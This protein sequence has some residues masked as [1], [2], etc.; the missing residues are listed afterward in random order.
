M[1]R[2]PS[3][4]FRHPVHFLAV[5]LGSGA[6]PVAPG[7]WGTLA[8]VP[9]YLPLS[10]LA[11]WGYLLFLLVTAVAG[12][13]ICGKTSRDWRVHDHAGIVWDE[14]VGFW[15]TMFLVPLSW[16]SLVLGF[17]LFRWFDI[18]KPW[19]IRYLDRNLQ[20]G[21]GIMVDDI[22]AGILACL[23]LHGLLQLPVLL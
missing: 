17:L 21:A 12:L 3:S 4:S 11:P 22:L 6:A 16:S 5:G 8:A 18:W 19:P 23:V 7:T 20:G 10:L 9:F 15:I 14:F 13:Y 2:V 1:N